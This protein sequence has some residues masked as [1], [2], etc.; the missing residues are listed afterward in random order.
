[1]NAAE[2]KRADAYA[3]PHNSFPLY[4]SGAHLRAAWDLAGHSADPA[5][6]RAKIRAF[7]R[8]HGLTGM[9]PSSSKAQKAFDSAVEQSSTRTAKKAITTPGY[10]DGN[11]AGEDDLH[12]MSRVGSLTQMA[13]SKAA[14]ADGEYG[15]MHRREVIQH[16][17]RHN[18]AKHLPA[19]AHG[20][21]H[22]HVMPHDHGDGN[23]SHDHP[24]V[25]ALPPVG[26]TGGDQGTGH[27]DQPGRRV[28]AMLDAAFD[29]AL[30]LDAGKPGEG[31]A[32]LIRFANDRNLLRFAPRLFELVQP[33]GTGPDS[34]DEPGT[35]SAGASETPS[36]ASD[37]TFAGD[38]AQRE[39][40]GSPPDSEVPGAE[41]E[42]I[43]SKS[44]TEI[45]LEEV[46]KT[47][48]KVSKAWAVSDGTAIVEGWVST[49]E[50]DQQHDIVP[51]EAFLPA[52]DGYATRRMPLSSEH[53][54]K[55]LP[56]GHGQ[57]VALIRDGQV[58]KSAKHPLDPAE[59]ESFPGTGTG[60]Y[61]RFVITEPQHAGAVKKGNVGGFSWV[62]ILTEY[63]PRPGGGRTFKRVEPWQESTIAAYPV[64]DTAVVVAAKA[65]SKED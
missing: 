1:M 17:Q 24:V 61:G 22:A 35:P 46:V 25:K 50:E 28:A 11:D 8:R 40:A 49:E 55:A 47:G 21:M 33:A 3:G 15:S 62:G 38:P 16:A 64:N 9:L 13:Y 57:Q 41:G 29:L 14:S 58:L 20:F 6:T 31:C 18:L 37:T 45:P 10:E 27:P 65:Q 48:L 19:E 63:E 53:Q 44:Y 59:F 54:M 43:V 34:Q 51:P 52:I 60:V 26:T 36:G 23:L 32:A 7:A 56:I 12:G 5:A 42:A 2:R 4:S 30:D 39:F